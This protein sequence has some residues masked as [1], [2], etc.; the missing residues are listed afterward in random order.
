MNTET[1]EDSKAATDGLTCGPRR[2]SRIRQFAFGLGRDGTDYCDAIDAVEEAL[3]ADGRL[4]ID[5]APQRRAWE[6]AYRAALAA[7]DSGDRER[8]KAIARAEVAKHIDGMRMPCNPF[9]DEPVD[10]AVLLDVELAEHDAPH[11]IET[12]AMAVNLPAE[13]IVDVVGEVCP[14]PANALRVAEFALD[15]YQRAPAHRRWVQRRIADGTYQEE[16]RLEPHATPPAAAPALAPEPVRAP[17]SLDDPAMWLSGRVPGT[18]KTVPYVRGQT[19]TPPSWRV[20]GLLPSI[21]LAI[22]YGE[23]QTGKSFLAMHLAQCVA[24][25]TPFFGRRTKAT[26]VLYVAAEGGAGVMPRLEA[27]ERALQPTVGTATLTG[28]RQAGEPEPVAVVVECPDLSR[29]GDPEA[30]YRTI[31]QAHYDLKQQ[32]SSLG[33]VVLDTWHASLGGG[34]EQGSADTGYALKPLKRAVEELG[35]LVLIVHHP[36]K[37]ADRGPRGSSSFGAAVETVIELV[38]PNCTGPRPKPAGMLRRATV[39]KQ[40]DGEAGRQFH[41]RMNVEQLGVD[42]DDEPWTTCTI[43]PCDDSDAGEL[44]QPKGKAARRLMA[45]VAAALTEAG[46]GK[47]EMRVVR[48]YFNNAGDPNEADDARRQAWNRALKW[49]RDNGAVETD[50]LDQLIWIPSKDPGQ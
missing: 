37:D 22:L 21:G 35:V 39:T 8:C 5:T 26:G 31:R 46:S 33:I 50:S 29:D 9:G 19:Y 42:E 7:W 2:F 44:G 41:F 48:G 4:G 38:V 13:D 36:G 30:L 14:L 6:K 28:Q 18:L 47:A 49:A 11:L 16:A 40:R 25:G 27:A 43:Q 20:K 17:T 10:T 1:I 23:S 3:W 45:A 12:V 15:D 34:D 24:W 32:G